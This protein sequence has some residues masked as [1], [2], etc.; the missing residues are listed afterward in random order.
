MNYCEK[1]VYYLEYV[2]IEAHER[3]QSFDRQPINLIVTEYWIQMKIWTYCKNWIKLFSE[4][5]NYAVKYDPNILVQAIYCTD[6]E[7]ISDESIS[8]FY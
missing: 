8:E 5:A 4:P 1:C 2:E 6:Y 7:L 3:K